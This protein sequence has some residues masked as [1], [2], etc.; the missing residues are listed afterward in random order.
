MI[1]QLTFIQWHFFH[2]TLIS[3]S[4]LH[5]AGCLQHEEIVFHAELSQFCWMQMVCASKW[6]GGPADSLGPWS[7]AEI[8]GK[9][10][11]TAFDEK[12]EFVVS[13]ILN[14]FAEKDV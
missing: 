2:F 8:P 6:E 7:A 14:Y 5:H 13:N 3:A 4:L 9:M 11:N 12:S 10:L 1:V